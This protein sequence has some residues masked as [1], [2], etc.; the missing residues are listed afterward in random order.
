MV[1][2]PEQVKERMM[3]KV[4]ELKAKKESEKSSFA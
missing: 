4:Q 2:T 3:Q 1:E